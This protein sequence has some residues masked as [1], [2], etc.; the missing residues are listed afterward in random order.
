MNKQFYRDAFGWGFVLWLIGYV[1]GLLLFAVVPASL[2]GWIITPI[3]IAIT[4][5]VLFK[6]VRKESFKNYLSLAFTWTFIAIVC[7][8]LFL[9][10]VFKPVGYY[11]LDVYLYYFITL[12]LP[13]LV[14]LKKNK[15]IKKSPERL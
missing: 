7:D 8:Y 3:G 2:I 4:L 11:K 1:L 12:L 14:G 10:A 15:E 13:I 6:K 5:W 9:V